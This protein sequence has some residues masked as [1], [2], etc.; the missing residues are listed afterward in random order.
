MFYLMCN[1]SIPGHMLDQSLI[2]LQ[3][4]TKSTQKYMVHSY[5]MFGFVD[6][7]MW[8][9]FGIEKIGELA[10]ECHFLTCQ[11]LFA[12]NCTYT[13]SSFTNIFTIQLVQNSPISYPSQLSDVQ[14]TNKNI[15]QFASSINTLACSISTASSPESSP[16]DI[17]VVID[18]P[19][20]Q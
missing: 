9:K 8:E 17:P 15:T 20:V 10:I 6:Y 18:G 2:I 11:L 12:I 14:C 1:L 13:C 4:T 3:A 16:V 5:F 19:V 7:C